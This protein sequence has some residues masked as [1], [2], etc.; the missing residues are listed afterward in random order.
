MSDPETWTGSVCV[1]CAVRGRVTRLE[2][3]H[4]CPACR[5]RIDDQ[6][7]DVLAFATEG[8]LRV[9][10]GS[11]GSG[12][13]VRTAPTS[14][15][16][17]NVEALD[18]A[19]TEVILERSWTRDDG[20]NDT[21]LGILENLAREV[22]EARK[23]SAYGPATEADTD[24]QTVALT[25]VVTFLRTHLE[26]I[27]EST[28][29]GLEEFAWLIQQCRNALAKWDPMRDPKQPRYA[30]HCP[31]S[32]DEV[33]ED[34]GQAIACGHR[35]IIERDQSHAWCPKC[36]RE[37]S[38]DRLLTITGDDA[39]VE[40]ESIASRLKV[41]ARSI[42]RWAKDGKVRRSGSLYRF[43]DVRSMLRDTLG[44]DARGA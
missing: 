1:L 35:L 36:R 43:G 40:A 5:V 25:N 2:S 21:V 4:C 27:T 11:G 12:T 26:W 15:P 6:L 16:P 7:R 8:A 44:E 10:L 42:R 9:E 29:V 20:N 22:R 30:C 14:R 38:V 41:T 13:G 17:I 31:T 32:T 18:P 33:D 23:L 28:D 19:M 3:G 34:T 37:W 24:S 39:Y